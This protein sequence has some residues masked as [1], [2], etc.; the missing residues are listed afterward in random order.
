MNELIARY[1]AS[2]ADF[3]AQLKRLLSWEERESPALVAETQT[4]V[5]DVRSRGDLAL[6]EYTRRFDQFDVADVSQ[7]RLEREHLE[8]CWHRAEAAQKEALKI[9]SDRIR[10]YHLE[11][12]EGGFEIR[13]EFKGSLGQR[14]T[15]IDRI[16][17]YVPGGQAAYPS[18]V[19]MTVVP[20]EVA[21]VKQVIVTV[22]TPNGE[23]N[24]LLAAALYLTNVDEVWRIGG[25][26]AIAA[27]AYGTESIGRVDKIVGPGGSWVTAAKKLVFGVVGIDGI[28]GPSE[29]LIVADGSVPARWTALD[30]MS[31]AEHDVAAQAILISSSCVYLD[32]V[33]QEITDLIENMPRREILKASFRRRGALIKTKDLE[34]AIDIS[35]QVAPEHLQLAVEN[36]RDVLNR[37]NNAGAVFLGGYSAEVL[38]DYIAGPSHVLPTFGTARYASP[39]GVYDFVKRSS[40]IELSREGADELARHAATIADAEGLQ[41]HAAAARV[42]I[43]NY[44]DNDPE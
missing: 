29:I 12:V 14:I 11:Q 7:L 37:V 13:D 28:A 5:D 40:I 2:D 26:Q 19:L 3:P 30:L 25:A 32:E 43:V 18:S 33:E 44:D 27:L 9:A 31:Q 35:N 10:E 1:S 22:P 36:P 23:I 24:D 20:A 41:S 39:L 15:P 42:R 8:R 34:E 6:V 16:G 38:G 4:I 21:G 17:V